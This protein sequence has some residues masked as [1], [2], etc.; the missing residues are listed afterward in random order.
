MQWPQGF[1]AQ[2]KL[3][4]ANRFSKGDIMALSACEQKYINAG[5]KLIVVKE[6]EDDST[7]HVIEVRLTGNKRLTDADGFE[8]AEEAN[9]AALATYFFDYEPSM[10]RTVN[11]FDWRDD[12]RDY[13]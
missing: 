3:K 11:S 5:G 9:Q 8:T 7:W 13:I 6:R 4:W 2:Q 10:I 1:L 12:C